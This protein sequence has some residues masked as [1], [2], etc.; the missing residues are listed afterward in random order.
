LNLEFLQARFHGSAGLADRPGNLILTSFN[1]RK[2]S[3]TRI[4]QLL[5]VLGFAAHWLVIAA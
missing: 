5:E 3:V 2:D 4:E 1:V